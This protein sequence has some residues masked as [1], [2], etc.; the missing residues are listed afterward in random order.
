[1]SVVRKTMFW[2]L[3]SAFVAVLVYLTLAFVVGIDAIRDS[4]F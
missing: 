2:V 3:V 4:P 1:M